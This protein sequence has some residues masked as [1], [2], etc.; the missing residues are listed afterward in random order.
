MASFSEPC[1]SPGSRRKINPRPSN[2]LCVQAALCRGRNTPR[3]ASVVSAS[4]TRHL[5]ATRTA[6]PRDC[7]WWA[8]PRPCTKA[9]R[10][11]PPFTRGY[12]LPLLRSY[13]SDNARF[14]CTLQDGALYWKPLSSLKNPFQR[15]LFT[16]VLP[17]IYFPIQEITTGTVHHPSRSRVRSCTPRGLLAEENA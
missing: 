1:R 5:P 2:Q 7:G 3:Q 10:G 17:G 15:L 4:A 13:S 8:N 16:Q 6:R 12:P 11:S 9:R 14:N